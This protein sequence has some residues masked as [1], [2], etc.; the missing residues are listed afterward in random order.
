MRCRASFPVMLAAVVG[1]AWLAVMACAAAEPEPDADSAVRKG[2]DF[3][4]S[5]QLPSGEFRTMVSWLAQPEKEYFYG[6]PFV[7]AFVLYSL[8]HAKDP[9]FSDV[10]ARAVK[11]F[12]EE[13]I[14][15]GVWAVY[16]KANDM[17]RFIPP[18]PP[19]LD[20]TGVI[21]RA[22]ADNGATI[23]NRPL[24]LKN[25]N[26]DGVFETFLTPNDPRW[27]ET[28]GVVNANVLFCLGESP[29]TRAA[30]LFVNRIVKDKA[31]ATCSR[32]YNGDPLPF[33]YCLSRARFHGASTLDSSRQP[34][35]D[36]VKAA[37]RPDGS[38]G[39]PLR[40]AFAA[41]TLINFGVGGPP[42]DRAIKHLLEAQA[43]DGS[44]PKCPFFGGRGI[45][46]GSKE[47]TTALAIE[48]ISRLPQAHEK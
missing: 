13:Q 36:R 16:S 20:C 22:L 34:V 48:A 33:Y 44:W 43:K 46:F 15:P 19:D 1:A 40:T 17:G 21:T 12:Q 5:S 26:A 24:F 30:A 27:R 32:W 38:F 2:F 45:T 39:D 18:V 3:L 42:L 31:E 7:S 14:R 25:R 41:C 28:D 11:F 23:E 10:A 9:R 35:V 29:E 47:F 37:Q 8:Q 4:V 6:S